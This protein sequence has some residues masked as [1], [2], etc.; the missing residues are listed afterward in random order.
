MNNW[1]IIDD[2]LSYKI[3]IMVGVGIVMYVLWS[4]YKELVD[5]SLI[6]VFLDYCMDDEF[7]F[8]LVYLKFNVLMVK[9]WVLIDFLF[10]CIG[11]V[12]FWLIFS[13]NFFG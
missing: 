6:Q 2:G 4:V 10:V 12:L 3:V 5:G 9:V 13:G 11:E 1:L 8:W 7:V